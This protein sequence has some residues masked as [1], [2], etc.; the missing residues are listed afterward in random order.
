MTAEKNTGT[1]GE[2]GEKQGATR[3]PITSRSSAES[4]FAYWRGFFWRYGITL[5]LAAIC[6]G[7]FIYELALAGIGNPLDI[8]FGEIP[9]G[10]IYEAGG[11]A[12]AVFQW[13][14]D[15]YR[16][17]TS[18]FVHGDFSHVFW[19]VLGLLA[20]GH[21]V[22]L[23]VKKAGM[24]LVVAASIL[25]DSIVVYGYGTMPGAESIIAFGASGVAFGL[26]GAGL[27]ML[28]LHREHAKP[29]GVHIYFLGLCVI[30]FAESLIFPNSGQIAHIAGFIG[31]VVAMLAVPGKDLRTPAPV[32][33]IATVA[34]I[35]V[36]IAFFVTQGR[37]WVW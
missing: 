23:G 26:I 9:L 37:L 10:V 33:A 14:D 27:A 17:V 12:P 18:V 25:A 24:A 22:E 16:F 3:R 1:P 36:T 32:R 13:P 11:I 19:N 20:A 4:E 35:A 34:L 15:C 29:F 28:A 21:L 2:R 6:I 31:G 7:V 30:Y 8:L 5:A